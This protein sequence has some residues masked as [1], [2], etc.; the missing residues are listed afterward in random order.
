MWPEILST[1]LGFTYR[2]GNN[3]AA[4]GATSSQILGQV[5]SLSAPTNAASALFVID[6][7]HQD[8]VNKTNELTFS[9]A[10]RS[11]TLNLS[12]SVVEC[13]RKGGRA[14][15]LMSMWDPNRSPRLARLIVDPVLVRERAQ[16]INAT[17]KTL[18]DQLSANSP[19]LR[20]WWIDMFA[21]FDAMVIHSDHF[22]FT[23]TDMGA[24]EDPQLTDKSYQGPGKDYMFWDSGHLTAKGHALL[25]KVFLAALRG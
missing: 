25:A 7:G 16:G 24:L 5:R 13:Y 14:V 17:L 15:V 6:V 4:G 11:A 8:F 21:L 2:P 23:R 3:R 9:N 22:G 19:D 18:A 1:N 10:L 20:L 12:N